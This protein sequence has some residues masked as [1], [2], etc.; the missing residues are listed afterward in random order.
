MCAS[1]I[2]RRTYRGPMGM[3]NEDVMSHPL[4]DD[5]LRALAE[6]DGSDLHVK[7]GSPPRIRVHGSLKRLDDAPLVTPEVTAEM[8]SAI[9]RDDV[10]E[11]FEAKNDADFAYAV[12]NLGRFRV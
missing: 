2:V 6:E 4:L 7:V 1:S 3:P 8:A 12:P 10:A 5:L 9:M 11:Q